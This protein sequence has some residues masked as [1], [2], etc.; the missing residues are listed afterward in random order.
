MTL[1][2]ANLISRQDQKSGEQDQVVKKFLTK[3]VAAAILAAI[4]LPA[5]LVIAPAF[6]QQDDRPIK[7]QADLIT[8]DATVTDKDG[9]F[10][11]GLKR[12]DFVV[13]EDNEPQLLEFFE[14]SE[15][16]ALTRPLAAVL[17][18]DMSGSIKPEEIIKQQE[19]AESFMKL[20]QPES[21]FAIVSFNTDTRVVQ[22]F[23]SDPKKIQQAFKRIGKPDGL[24]RIFAALDKSVSML[25]R[26]PRFRNGRRLRRVV[27]IITDGYAVDTAEE[28]N[29][30]Q[31]ANDAEV[32]VYSVTLPSYLG[33]TGGGQRVMTLLD[34]SRVVP[35]TGG[36]DF[37]A[38]V[39]DFTPVFK[40]IAEEIRSGYT[41]AYSP[42]EKSK[43]DGQVHQIRVEVK[44]SGAI[45]R[46]SRTSYQAT[47]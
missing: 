26:A 30:I 24:T 45:V 35:M 10:I 42:P 1:A 27:I 16:A 23:T 40:A 43:R 4:I 15:K 36:A 37:S 21:V 6:G 25:K 41:L 13:Y 19:A 18:F 2:R 3:H 29:L 34:V 20:V 14:S 17:A 12:E 22:D 33:A 47:P 32:T 7:L 46:S 5:A 38:D 31:R 28:L 8:I 9:N 39:R 11:R 44:R